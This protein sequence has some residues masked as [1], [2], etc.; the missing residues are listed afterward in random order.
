[1]ESKLDEGTTFRL[2]FKQGD[3]LSIEP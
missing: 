3:P 2:I 1:V